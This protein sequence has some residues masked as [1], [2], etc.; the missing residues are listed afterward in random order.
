M[1]GASSCSVAG[2]SVA[3]PAKISSGIDTRSV[4]CW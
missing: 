2:A 4:A 3:A 1:I